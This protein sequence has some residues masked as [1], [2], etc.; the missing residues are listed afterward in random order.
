MFKAM[1]TL[2]LA[3]MFLCFV[4]AAFSQ[5]KPFV[6]LDGKPDD[7]T[8]KQMVEQLKAGDATVDFVKFRDA[9]LEWILDECNVSDAP[10]RDA[11]LKAFQDKDYKR[12][13]V[14]A[15][16]VLD[17]EYVNR[18][19]HRAVA[20]A[21]KELGNAEKA[22]FHNDVADLL[23]KALMN[24]GD[25]QST[26]TAYRVHSIREEYIVMEELGYKVSIQ[27]LVSDKDYGIFDVLEGTAKDGKTG[28]F[29]FKITDI[30]VGSTSSKPCKAKKG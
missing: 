2:A 14:I 25:G 24:S 26:K 6:R 3:A 23:M 12:A 30:W 7:S 1:R 8:Y 19:L 4:S 22:K 17:Y 5:S 15:D 13:V 11:M 16:K 10:D 29:Y 21:Y 9:Y 28:R 18:S 20:N 27:S